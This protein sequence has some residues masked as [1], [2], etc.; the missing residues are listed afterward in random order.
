MD[1]GLEGLPGGIHCL[2]TLLDEHQEA[3]EYDLISLGLRLA[4]LGTGRLTWR[5]LAVIVRHSPRTSALARAVNG[6]ETTWSLTD[7]LLAGVYDLL[8]LANWQRAGKKNSPRPRPLPRPG[9]AGDGKRIGKD[10]IPIR[11]FNTWWEKGA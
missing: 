11:D 9:K 10:P 7:H 2:L 4:W 3:I 5:D 1:G 6:D 8:A